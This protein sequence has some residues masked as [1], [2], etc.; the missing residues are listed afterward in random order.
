[1]LNTQAQVAE[2]AAGAAP[3][4]TQSRAEPGNASQPKRDTPRGEDGCDA[5]EASVEEDVFEQSCL[6]VYMIVH[7]SFEMSA[8]V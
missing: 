8:C 3:G 1:M 7:M 6:K 4:S 2:V 5:D